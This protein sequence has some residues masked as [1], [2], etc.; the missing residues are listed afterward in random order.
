MHVIGILGGVASG[1]SAVA[2]LLAEAGAG[3]L[4]ADRIGHEV[5]GLAEVEAAARARWGDA[6]FDAAGRID[7]GRLAAIVFTPPPEGPR[8]RAAL[9]ELTH[10]RIAE[11]IRGE[12]ERLAAAGCPAA[13]L[14][15]PLLLEANWDRLCDRLVFVEAPRHVRL[16]RALERGWSRAEFAAR[17]HA[18]TPVEQKRARAD[19][20]IENSGDLEETR[21]QV[22]RFWRELLAGEPARRSAPGPG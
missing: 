11:R 1:K 10:P 15:A 6:I 18:Q 21:E 4:D 8:E 14:D 13:V 7:R 22:L 5:L 20:I 17:E 3:V 9:E 16:A 19:L 12:A 2:R